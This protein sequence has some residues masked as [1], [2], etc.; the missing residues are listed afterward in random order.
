M[1]IG[2][3]GGEELILQITENDKRLAAIRAY[4]LTG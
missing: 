4:A 1:S 3:D 2:I